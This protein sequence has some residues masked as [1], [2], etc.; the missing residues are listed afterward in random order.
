LGLP[1]F[2]FFEIGA[3]AIFKDQS[4]IANISFNQVLPQVAFS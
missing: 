2:L 4:S 3:S 1:R